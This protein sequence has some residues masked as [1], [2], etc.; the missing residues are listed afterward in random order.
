MGSGRREGFDKK[1]TVED[2][3]CAL[4][5]ASLSRGGYLVPGQFG[6]IT[7][8]NVATG[9]KRSAVSFT[10]ALRADGLYLTLSYR[11]TSRGADAR[12]VEEPIR[13]TTTPCHFGGERWWFL[14]PLVVDGRPCGR[15]VGKL[16]M[17]P[18]ATY[19]GCRHCYDLT[20]TSAQE[21]NKQVD[22]YRANPE[23]LMA[24][25]R[26]PARFNL[27]ACRAAL[28]CDEGRRRG[29]TR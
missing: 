8:R 26:D 5:V 12:S 19:F 28:D 10:T 27:A 1:T 9:E 6:A 22:F 25:L 16:Y 15:R 24:A 3:T 23:A 17:P 13:L 7:W 21:H 29:W 2:C 14:C 4:D 18:S 11:V 20:Y